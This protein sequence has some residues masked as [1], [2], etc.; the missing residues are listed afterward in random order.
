MKSWLQGKGAA[1][2]TDARLFTP[3]PPPLT[4]LP[5]APALPSASAPGVHASRDGG[6]LGRAEC[7]PWGQKPSCNPAKSRVLENGTY[8]LYLDSYLNKRAIEGILGTTGDI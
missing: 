2:N 3:I 7:H 6:A 8:F 1:E 4:S 5:P